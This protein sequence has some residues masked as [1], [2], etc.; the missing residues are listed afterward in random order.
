M[1]KT[2]H[3]F[4]L[5]LILAAIA[6]Q[7]PGTRT[8][9]STPT[10][11]G[12][13]ALEEETLF[14]GV[15]YTR[16][17]RTTPRRMVLHVITIDLRTKGILPFVTPGDPTQDL[18]LDARTTSQFLEEFGVQIAI[19]GDGFTPWSTNPLDPYPK[20]GEPVNPLGLSISDGVTYSLPRDSVPTLYFAP[21][22]KANFNDP[23]ANIAHAIS[24]LEMIVLNGQTLPDLSE[25]IEPRTAL[26]LNRGNK[27]L[28]LVIVDGRQT[29]YSEGATLPELAA[30]LLEY[31]VHNGMNMDGGGSS[32]LVIEGEDGLPVV[33]NSPIDGNIPG[34][35]RPVANHL[36]IFARKK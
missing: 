22:G 17:V 21:S 8:P 33:L 1:R 19:N 24:G 11:S 29:G 35:E 28:T 36:G 13:T 2:K 27:I 30:I 18:P 3:L 4:L 7:M 14:D 9:S 6:C 10:G 12:A 23:P 32:T 31:G 26:G 16:E 25:N 34:R 20:P 5:T 15:T